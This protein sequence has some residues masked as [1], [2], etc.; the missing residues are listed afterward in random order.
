MWLPVTTP[1][2]NNASSRIGI[3]GG[4]FDP[5]HYGHLRPALELAEAYCLKTLYLLPNHR[6]VHRGPAR[7]STATRIE[8]LE[9]AIDKTQRL[10][11]DTREALRD[12]PSYSFDTLSE[13]RSEHPRA[14]LLF[15]MGLD[16]FAMYDTWHK[17]QEI[18]ELTNLVIM[19][20]PNATHSRFSAQLLS[21]QR[22]TVGEKVC[23]G[24]SGAIEECDVTQL[25]ISS[26]DIR[27]R[28]SENLTIRF[29]LP[30]AVSEY[31][32]SNG[33]YRS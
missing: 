16:A 15:F 17:W 29:L 14:T 4:T 7:A 33:L 10:A 30:D 11:V 28:V 13:V 21:H 9:L 25:E 20:R 12:K 26:T 32:M 2:V 22:A 8:M 18:L 19:H 27:R 24:I 3:L 5:V 31:I 23:D 6:P 1:L